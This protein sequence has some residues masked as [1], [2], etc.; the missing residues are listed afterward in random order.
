[1]YLASK[2]IIVYSENTQNKLSANLI[3]FKYFPK[4]PLKISEAIPPLGICQKWLSLV[5]L[6]S[7]LSSLWKFSKWKLFQLFVGDT[8]VPIHPVVWPNYTICSAHPVSRQREIILRLDWRLYA[9]TGHRP[10]H[11][12]ITSK[13][14]FRFRLISFQFPVWSSG[15]MKL[16]SVLIYRHNLWQRLY[17]FTYCLSC[18]RRH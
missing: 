18:P 2:Y 4:F 5:L 14:T 3:N 16:W 12:N 17:I 7:A 6:C 10:G 11:K 13:K 1:M 9:G 8:G 15:R